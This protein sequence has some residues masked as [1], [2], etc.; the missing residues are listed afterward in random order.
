MP[1]ATEITVGPEAAIGARD[2]LL[3]GRVDC[4]LSI[5][6]RGGEGHDGAVGNWIARTIVNWFGFDHQALRGSL[7]F[8]AQIARIRGH[9]PNHT[10]G[11][12]I[13]ERGGDFE[14]ARRL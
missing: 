7:A 10:M 3:D 2:T 12:Q 5:R 1:E 8:D 14:R 4:A 9:L 11:R 6:F 13:I